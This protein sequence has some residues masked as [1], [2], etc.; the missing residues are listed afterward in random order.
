MISKTTK[1]FFIITL[2]VVFL[3]V[4]SVLYCTIPHQLFSSKERSYDMKRVHIYLNGEDVTDQCDVP[5]LLEVLEQ[6][7]YRKRLFPTGFNQAMKRRPGLIQISLK[8]NT[9][10]EHISWV[11]W[12]L[13]LT[14]E[15]Q[16]CTRGSYQWM[17][18]IC[19]GQDLYNTI[20]EMLPE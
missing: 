12:D 17:D 11:F 7:S 16:Y 14:P 5:A 6:V 9:S 20:L 15:W 8:Y 19:D 1:N 10:T 2:G 3:I 18:S 4:L 13:Y